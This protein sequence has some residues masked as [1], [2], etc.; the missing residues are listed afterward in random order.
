M[1]DNYYNNKRQKKTGANFEKKKRKNRTCTRPHYK[2]MGSISVSGQL[3]TPSS[4]PTVTLNC[5]QLTI[6]EL[7]EGQ[8][9]SCPD[10][11]I[12]P[13]NAIHW[14]DFESCDIINKFNS[15]FQ[16]LHYCKQDNTKF[17]RLRHATFEGFSIRQKSCD[18]YS[19]PSI[20]REC[21]NP[22]NQHGINIRDQL[23]IDGSLKRML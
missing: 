6:V 9:G 13:K 15:Q 14:Q 21:L 12:D 7:G 17:C 20:D 4:N 19:L 11:D 5:C 23:I 18:S 3:P 8:V 16:I 10:T 22:A 2:K 1:D